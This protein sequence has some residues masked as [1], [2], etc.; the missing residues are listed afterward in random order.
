MA[1]QS[2]AH[3]V[4]PVPNSFLFSSEAVRT[5]VDGRGEVWFCA[6]DVCAALDITWNGTGN[7]LKS[8]PEHW[9]MA[10]S[11]ETIKGERDT[12]FVSEPGLYRLIFR[13][14]KAKAVEFADWVCADVLAAI[15][16]Q[17]FYGAISAWQQI[18]LS[19]LMLK[20]LSTLTNP[21]A[22]VHRLV[23]KRLRNVCNLLGEPMPSVELLGQD[24]RLVEK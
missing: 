1:I 9:V 12:V 3:D 4:R 21:D 18:Q 14:N 2:L 16:K 17:G 13:S 11:H 24:R 19:N 20:L 7:T 6:K 15:R 23:I 5:A 8:L 10:S 22:F